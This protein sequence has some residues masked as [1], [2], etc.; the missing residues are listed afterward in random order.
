MTEKVSLVECEEP[1]QYLELQE[2]FHEPY[3]NRQRQ[4][5]HL[6]GKRHKP[7]DSYVAEKLAAEISVSIAST[8]DQP[9]SR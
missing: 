4:Y 5:Q 3:Q 8:G 2:A 6:A 7:A 9:S 1:L